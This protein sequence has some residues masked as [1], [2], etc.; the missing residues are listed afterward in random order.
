MKTPILLATLLLSSLSISNAMASDFTELF[1]PEQNKIIL[2]SIDDVCADSWCEGNYNLKFIN[3]TC[4]KSNSACALNFIFIETIERD[5]ER[6]SPI[7][8]CHFKNIRSY[9]QIMNGNHSL[10]G[11]FYDRVSDCIS[12]K[13]SSVQF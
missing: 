8:V 6:Y 11:D 12:N 7:Q 5:E 2:R 10:N 3:F 13:E 4:D 9:D 1:T